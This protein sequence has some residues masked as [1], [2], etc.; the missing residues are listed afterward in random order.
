MQTIACL[1]C[2][3]EI[4]PLTAA[5]NEGLCIP[6][7]R[8][9]RTQCRVC[10]APAF[11]EMRGAELPPLCMKCRVEAERLRPTT[12]ESFVNERGHGDCSLL[13]GLFKLDERLRRDGLDSFIGLNLIDPPEF[14]G[15]EVT[16]RNTIAFA[17][18]GGNDVHFSLVTVKGRVSDDGMVLMTCPDM[19]DA[20]WDANILV[21]ENLRDFL[22]LGCEC[23]YDTIENLPHDREAVIEQLRS[24]SDPEE[25]D[26]E[27]RA[28]LAEYRR[29]LGLKPWTDVEERLNRL[30]SRKRFALRF[31]R[32][33]P[34]WGLR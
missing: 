10:G 22:S 26:E 28:T 5:K 1:A 29:A 31:S 18:T 3:A 16:P 12:I 8:G 20:R 17:G 2:G 25:Q 9:V 4:Q 7:K 32:F 33:W 13:V 24:G 34:L 21:G 23:G 30:E 19:G 11:K 27:E 6:C 14:Y 15:S